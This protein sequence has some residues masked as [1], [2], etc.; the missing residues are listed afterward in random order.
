MSLKAPTVRHSVYILVA[1]PCV[2]TSVL[3]PN[4]SR[5]LWLQLEFLCVFLDWQLGGQPTPTRWGRC[6]SA[7]DS[8][9]PHSVRCLP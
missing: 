3:L 4:K 5:F 7:Q 2:P 9:G 8:A 6:F 1:M